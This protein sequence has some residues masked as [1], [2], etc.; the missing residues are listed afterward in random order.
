MYYALGWFFF[1]A[2][3][4]SAPASQIP[5]VQCPHTQMRA[6]VC[7]YTYLQKRE[8]TRAHASY[9]RFHLAHKIDENVCVHAFSG[10]HYLLIIWPYSIA[11]IPNIICIILYI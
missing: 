6:C 9:F 10:E 8:H 2:S 3:F 7:V 5:L 1:F 4:S 11:S